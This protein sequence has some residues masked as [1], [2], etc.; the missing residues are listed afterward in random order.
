MNNKILEKFKLGEKISVYIHQYPFTLM[1]D[2][3]RGN[4][5]EKWICGN[6]LKFYD[7]KTFS[8]HCSCC[9]DDF[10]YECVLTVYND[11]KIYII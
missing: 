7:S 9:E 6:C 10:C 4:K 1:D 3:M 5:G 8:F 11:E 2:E